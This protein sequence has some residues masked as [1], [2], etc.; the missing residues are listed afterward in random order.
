MVSAGALRTQDH[1]VADS[2][3]LHPGYVLYEYFSTPLKGA[4]RA[5]P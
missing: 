3:A 1:N 2:G 5:V 4:K